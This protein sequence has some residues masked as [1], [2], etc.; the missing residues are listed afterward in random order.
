MLELN[1]SSDILNLR[2]SVF[3]KTAVF[4]RGFSKAKYEKLL[5]FSLRSSIK[6]NLT[7]LPSKDAF[8]KD[9]SIL[10]NLETFASIFNTKGLVLPA[11]HYFN[12]EKHTLVKNLTEEEMTLLPFCCLFLKETP[13]WLANVEDASLSE[14]SKEKV[15]GLFSSKISNQ[16]SIVLY[17]TQTAQSLNVENEIEYLN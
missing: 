4:F 17:S 7:I 11:I 15:A 2:L 9:F 1:Y 8:K 6:K 5:L 13:I 3:P 14:A 12:L 10:Q 16:N